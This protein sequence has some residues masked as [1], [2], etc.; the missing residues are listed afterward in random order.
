MFGSRFLCGVPILWV[1][2]IS[3]RK[4]VSWFLSADGATWE[5]CTPG[6]LHTFGVQ[7]STLQY[8]VELIT[9]RTDHS[10]HIYNITVSYTHTQPPAAPALTDPGAEAPAG[11]IVISWAAST[12]PDGIVDHYVLQSGNDATFTVVLATYPT[13]NTDYT[14]SAPKSGVFSSEFERLTMTALFQTGVTWKTSPSPVDSHHLHPFLVSPLK[15]S[16]SEPSLLLVQELYIVVGSGNLRF[17][18]SFFP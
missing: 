12:D 14:V 6:M 5:P 13:P 9:A 10:A 4:S 8:R 2:H 1:N 7:G 15:P 16:P 3:V 18:S 11:N 17:P